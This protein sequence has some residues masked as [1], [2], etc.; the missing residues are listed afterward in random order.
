MRRSRW[1]LGAVLLAALATPVPDRPAAASCAAA[2]LNV[3]ERT[4]LDRGASTTVT[5]DAFADGCQDS[6]SCT[7]TLGCSSCEADD[8]E[9]TPARDVTLRLVQ[10]DRTWVLGT[11]DAQEAGSGHLGRVTWTVEIPGDAAPGPA[12]LVAD[13]APPVRVRVR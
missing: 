4:L 12:R 5:G 7:V 10:G 11:A 8:P 9:P 6:E 3:A 1:L 2:Y 13:S